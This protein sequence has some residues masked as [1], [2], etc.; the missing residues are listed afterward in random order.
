MR[1]GRWLYSFGIVGLLL[2]P[3]ALGGQE[4]KAEAALKPLRD[5][6][7]DPKADREKLRQELLLF[8]R[9]HPG[10]SSALKAA[11]LLAQLPSPLDRLDPKVIPALERFNWQPKELV[12]LLGEHRGRQGGAV[13][14]VAWSAD[15]RLIASGSTNGLVRL[16]DPRTMRQQH[17]LG[18]S[19][20]VTALAF[21]RESKRLAAAGSDGSVR[22]WDVSS[23]DKIVPLPVIKA[24]STP[25][26]ALAFSP[27]SKKLATGGHD[28]SIR[29][30]DLTVEKPERALHEMGQGK[31]EITGLAF[32]P[33][34]DVLYSSDQR[35]AVRVW[36]MTG[37]EP[38]E[39]AEVEAHPKSVVALALDAKGQTL[40]T[41]SA[42]GVIGIWR[43]GTGK[44]VRTVQFPHAGVR[45]LAFSPGGGT[46]AA[47][48]TDRTAVL[49]DLTKLPPTKRMVCEAHKGPFD[50]HIAALS[51]VA[52]DPL[53]RAV[54]TGSAD[55]TV[56]LW[57]LAGARPAE[58]EQTTVTRGH[59]S[60][61]YSTSVAPDGQTLASGSYDGSTRLWTLTAAEPKERSLLRGDSSAIYSVAYSPDGRTL[62]S[63]GATTTFR[64]WDAVLGR[65]LRKFEGHPTSITGLEF[66]GDG[67]H[68]LCTSGKE[69]WLWDPNTPTRVVR[70][71][72]GHE[73][74]I[75]GSALSP[76]GKRVLSSSGSYKYDTAG[77]PITKDGKYVYVDP[78]LRLWDAENG[79]ELHAVTCSA[80]LARTAFIPDGRGLSSAWDGANLIWDLTGPQPRETA[81]LQG[82]SGYA[83][84]LVPS[85]D[86]TKL[87][88]RWSNGMLILWDLDTGKVLREWSLPE[89]LAG[90][91]WASDSRHLVL[92]YGTG[93]I[94]ILRLEPLKAP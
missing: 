25:L 53:G 93:V 94:N 34:G 88:T 10:T 20:A 71:F 61:I 70:R 19:Y 48:S 43:L 58:P 4:E 33:K 40:A 41:A 67:R 91:A 80:A 64:L 68:V 9:T 24:S 27:D 79:K 26:Y 77:R 89:S 39:R 30:Y 38:A 63:G 74:P 1:A 46:L 54:V 42:D 50:G 44:P 37:A 69:M 87:A 55:W 92:G 23:A 57:P 76:D 12:A 65:E 5:R 62:A 3:L 83:T 32:G 36:D 59:L 85:P 86:G 60:L 14:A 28:T 22:Q 81:S 56:R 7:A 6:F 16:W 2:F 15:S 49:W 21:D 45:C 13:S 82:R 17:L 73:L 18:N 47:G 84:L 51:A 11:Q 66:S 31:G 8:R 75:S 29:V 35:G 90:L 72:E 52:F 78:T